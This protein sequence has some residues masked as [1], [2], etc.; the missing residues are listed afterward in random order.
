ME[1]PPAPELE[2]TPQE[3]AADVAI[4]QDPALVT[5]RSDIAQFATK[6]GV[7]HPE[8]VPVGIAME[9]PP[10][11]MDQQVSL[12]PE[13]EFPPPE[14]PSPHW[15]DPDVRRALGFT[16]GV[17]ATVVPAPDAAS[18]PEAGM[19]TQRLEA[20]PVP[21]VGVDTQPLEVMPRPEA[22][23]AEL[24]TPQP[25]AL[26]AES[27][28][29]PAAESQELTQHLVEQFAAELEAAQKEAAL[30]PAP[31]PEMEPAAE[32]AIAAVSLDEQQITEAVTRVLERYKG[33]LIAAIVKELK[34]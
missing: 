15:G 27:A 32:A 16:G 34:P 26:S 24:M 8:D 22:G 29:S 5:D 3:S 4:V 11:A 12:P 14:V 2:V 17:P 7:E 20:A 33:V 21:E 19:D 31:Q 25:A 6:F 1:V 23:I 9:P 13:D 30:A 28:A 18:E 10:E